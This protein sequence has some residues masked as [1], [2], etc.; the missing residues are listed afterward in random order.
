[1]T[2]RSDE[3]DERHDVKACSLDVA[4]RASDEVDEMRNVKAY[5]LDVPRG[6]SR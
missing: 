1:M 5:G 3:G 4:R 6:T 2:T